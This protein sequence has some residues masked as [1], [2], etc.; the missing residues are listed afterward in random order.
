MDRKIIE[1]FLKKPTLAT[2]R[3]GFEDLK[4]DNFNYYTNT[5]IKKIIQKLFFINE[6]FQFINI[7]MWQIY[8]RL[9]EIFTIRPY[10]CTIRT[11]PNV[12]V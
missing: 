1:K 11:I 7:N 4:W 8:M 10:K 6:F 2:K 3:W 12:M 9:P 5:I